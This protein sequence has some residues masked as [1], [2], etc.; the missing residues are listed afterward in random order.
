MMLRIDG[1]IHNLQK[2]VE[3]L[4]YQVLYGNEENKTVRTNLPEEL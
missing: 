4:S 1:N 2:L 3:S